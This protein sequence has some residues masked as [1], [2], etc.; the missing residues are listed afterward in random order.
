MNWKLEDVSPRSD[1][2]IFRQVIKK[3]TSR[4]TPNDGASVTG[5]LYTTFMVNGRNVS[6]KILC[7]SAHIIGTYEKKTFDDRE[8]K[9]NIG[10]IPEDEVISGIQHA[11]LHFGKGETSRYMKIN[12]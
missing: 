5:E 8:V 2:G 4:K 7:I 12:K 6:L 1:G 9:F 10:E 11:L 3:A